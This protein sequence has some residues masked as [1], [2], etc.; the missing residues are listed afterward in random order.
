MLE[1]LI[2]HKNTGMGGPPGWEYAMKLCFLDFCLL[3]GLSWKIV[4]CVFQ[5]GYHKEKE[6]RIHPGKGAGFCFWMLRFS[7]NFKHLVLE[8]L[9]TIF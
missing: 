2:Y 8:N 3:L 1:T 5:H 4:S 9:C 7:S 6:Q